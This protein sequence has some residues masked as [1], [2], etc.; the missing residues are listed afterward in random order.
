M[1]YPFSGTIPY[2]PEPEAHPVFDIVALETG[3]TQPE[4]TSGC[5]KRAIVIARQMVMYLL[6]HRWGLTQ[7]RTGSLVGTHHTSVIHGL[8]T[9]ESEYNRV[10]EI[11]AALDRLM[12]A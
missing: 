7:E 12:T 8:Q 6:R 3:V 11:R 4:I 10:P 2:N 9:I 1:N 5:R